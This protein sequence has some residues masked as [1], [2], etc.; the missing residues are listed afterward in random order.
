MIPVNELRSGAVF[1]ESGQPYS[2]LKYNHVK[3]GRGNA[4]VKIKARNL[5]TGSTIE[6]SYL[7]GASVEEADVE[8]TKVQYLYK[9]GNLYSFMDV[10]SYEQ[11]ELSSDFLSDNVFFLKEGENYELLKFEGSPVS[12]ELPISIVLKVAETGSGFKGD[13]VSSTGKPAI[14]ETGLKADVPLFINTGD[15]VKIDT[16]DGSYVGRA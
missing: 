15:T 11:L 14:L 3:M 16:R 6:K 13:T 4:V 2:V 1:K 9:A 12:L 8:K 10:R 7:S 5:K